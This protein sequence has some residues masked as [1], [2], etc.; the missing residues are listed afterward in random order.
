MRGSPT[1]P[2]FVPASVSPHAANGLTASDDGLRDQAL[3]RIDEYQVGY[4]ALTRPPPFAFS[5]TFLASI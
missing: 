3:K 2:S 5:H 1:L 4:R